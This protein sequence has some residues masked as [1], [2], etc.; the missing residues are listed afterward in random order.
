M[1][2]G[3][4]L[5]VFLL[6][7]TVWPLFQERG[8]LYVSAE[9]SSLRKREVEQA[10]RAQLR[11]LEDDFALGRLDED[12]YRRLKN[13][14]TTQGEPSEENASQTEEREKVFCIQCGQANPKAAR[15]CMACGSKIDYA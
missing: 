9:E 12:D 7:W 4:I 15:F 3:F 8:L 10:R 11:E 6:V 13:T 5:G 1:I 2:L 14:F